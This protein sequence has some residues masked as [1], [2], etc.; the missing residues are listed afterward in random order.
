MRVGVDIRCL[1]DGRRT[2]VEE[3]TLHLLR[4]MIAAA[5]QHTFVLFANS[6]KPMRL[7]AL[8]GANVEV[9]TFHYPNGLFNISLKILQRPTLDTLIGGA[10]VFF[11]PSVRLAPLSTACPLVLTVHDLSFVR[12]PEFFSRERRRWHRLMEPQALVRR[13]SAILTPSTATGRDVERLY[14]IPSSRIRVVYSGLPMA[15]EPP[16]ALDLQRVRALYGLPEEFLL[17]VG[18]LEPRK[19]IDSLLAAYAWLRQKGHSHALVLAGVRGWIDTA[20]V[21]RVETHPFTQDIHLTGGIADADKSALYQLAD[22]FVYPSF[23]EGF[24]FPPL[25]A[26]SVGTPVVTSYNSAIPEIV[27]PWASLV[28]PSDPQ[29]LAAV[30]SEQVMRPR[31]VPEAVRHAVRERYTWQRAAAETL[32]VFHQVVRGEV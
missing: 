6:R 5:P 18:T 4:A 14:A 13:A 3:Y 23:Y 11:V 10:D 1:M 28:N 2:G 15:A 32:E 7:P 17:F 16:T 25:E 20:F 21:R 12:H 8:E 9:R 26:L 30:L 29:E 22:L 27:G 24:G 19:N 31:R